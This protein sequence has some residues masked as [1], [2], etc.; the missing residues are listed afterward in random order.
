MEAF[1]AVC[2]PSLPPLLAGAE[3]FSPPVPALKVFSSKGYVRRQG[4]DGGGEPRGTPIKAL[5]L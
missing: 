5:L 1:A 4:R 2:M 3:F